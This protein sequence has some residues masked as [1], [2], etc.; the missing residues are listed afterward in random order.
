MATTLFELLAKV[1]LDSSEYESGLSRLA[2]GAKTFAKG[3][4]VAISAAA[5]ATTAFAATA[6]KSGMEFD[7]AMSQVAATMGKTT[8]EI[9][10]L[11][12]F[13][14]EMGRTTAFSATQAAEALNYMALAGYDAETAMSTLPTVLDL[15]A[16][17]G[18]DLAYASDMITDTQSALGLSLDETITLVDQMAKASSKSN[19]SVQQ[20]GEALL[21]VGGTAKNMAGGTNEMATVLGVLADN[22]IKGTEGGTHLRNMILRLSAPTEKGAKVLDDLGVAI[23]NAEGEMRSFADIFP[24]LNAAMSD[25]TDEEK[26]LAISELFNLTDLSAANALLATSTERWEDL[27]AQIGEAEGAAGA[28]ATTQL[29]N[30][31]GD[32][33][34]F[35][36]ALEGAQ[37]AVSDQLTPSL[38]G[39]VSFGSEAISSLTEAFTTG[40]FEGA[41]GQ[42]GEL[43]IT[44]LTSALENAPKLLNV[45]VTLIK[46]LVDGLKKN[47]KLIGTSAVDIITLLVNSVLE[48]LPDIVELGLEL[49]VALA[50]GLADNVDTI[51][52]TVTDVV[53]EMVDLL[54]NPDTLSKMVDVALELLLALADGLIKALPR[55]VEAIPKIIDNLMTALTTNLPKITKAATTLI[56]QLANALVENA[57]SIIQAGI[58]LLG[59]LVEDLPTI[60]KSITDVLPDLVQ[61]IIDALLEPDNLDAMI[62]AGIN[63]LF[64]LVED[65]PAIIGAIAGAIPDIIGGIIGTIIKPENIEKF[66]EAG[67]KLW[68]GLISKLPDVVGTAVG[69]IA[70][71]FVQFWDWLTG[72]DTSDKK[73]TMSTHTAG[74]AYVEEWDRTTA[75]TTSGGFNYAD[76]EAFAASQATPATAQP[77]ILTMQM[78]SGVEVGRQYIE[79][80]N[81]AQRADGG[82]GGRR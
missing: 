4:T 62:D 5:T 7:T 54:T 51:L 14:Q 2:T 73:S 53:L 17:G 24:E 68:D 34:L 78:P 69:N 3:A 33:T 64:A 16:A 32:I 47:A 76:L 41:V 26:T 22:G 74:V 31:A 52:E 63:L 46:T 82:G 81:A 19:T 77:I 21:T 37:I 44:A 25:M 58:D 28:M 43:L 75:T 49:I 45:A 15:A 61:G 59:A 80:I 67:K 6:V 30:L 23:F 20:L 27:S 40:G 50:E 72:K 29:D 42:L 12:D 70:D 60:I 39:L 56:T 57:P 18:I 10:E 66:K 11:R 65:I 36:S 38:R 13:A 35:K 79:D 8:D 9:T 48:M 55:L 71:L 1:G